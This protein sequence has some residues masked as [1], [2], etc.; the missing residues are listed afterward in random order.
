MYLRKMG[1]V[2]LIASVILWMLGYFPKPDKYS[3][4][5]ETQIE[6][7][8]SLGTP[9]ANEGISTLEAERA[10]EDLSYSFIGRLGTV[11]SPIVSPLGFNWQMGVSL[12]PGFVAKEVV[13]SSLGV[14]YFLGEDTNEASDNL[15]MALQNPKSGITRAAAYA[16]M[17]FILLYTPCLATVVA[18]RKEI[19][20]KWMWFSITFQCLFAWIGAFAVYQLLSLFGL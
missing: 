13:V 8:T 3:Q 2:I 7:L 19:G 15:M 16:F 9:E 17:V 18:I 14:L 5:Y 20:A 6:R 11:M 10:E 1:G 12:I 4:D